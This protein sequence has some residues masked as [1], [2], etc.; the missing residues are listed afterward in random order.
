MDRVGIEG[1]ADRLVHID[2]VGRLDHPLEA[3]DVHDDLIVHAH[4][5]HAGDETG[6]LAA[7]DGDDVHVLGPDDHVDRLARVEALV[8]AGEGLA[9]EGD[10]VVLQHHAVED[11][12]L[13]D[14]VGDEGVDRLVVDV[15]RGADLVDLALGH[16]DDGVGHGQ[17]LLLVVGDEDEGDARLLLDL[18]QLDL[19]VLA[20]LQVQGTERLVEQQDAGLGH[21]G[22]GDGHALLLAA[23]ETGDAALLEPGQRH[24]GEH[25][26]HAAVDLVAGTFLL[27]QGEG[28][29]L[30]DRQ[31][32][33]E[34]VLLEHGVHAAPVRGDLV[35]PL[36]EEDDVALVGG[37]EPADQPQERGLAAARGAEQGEELVVVDVQVDVLEDRHTVEGF[38]DVFQFDDLLHRPT[39]QWK[40]KK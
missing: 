6:E 36:A 20:E 23:G 24:E 33:E 13:A 19:H 17:G 10:L 39:L 35:D 14:E 40:A 34:R 25:L 5:G 27:A 11:V 12:A 9:G 30:I 18:L 26:A 31:M 22:A 7:L 8:Q 2:E 37:L 1:D 4:E 32:G 16:D 38:G 29:V 3:A 28:D 15:D 21:E